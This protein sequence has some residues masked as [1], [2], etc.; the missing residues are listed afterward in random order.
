[1]K[2]TPERK[3]RKTPNES[4]YVKV[5]V[6][7]HSS[8]QFHRN[9]ILEILSVQ[10]L[11]QHITHSSRNDCFKLN[12]IMHCVLP[13]NITKTETSRTVRR[14]LYISCS[15]EN[16]QTHKM[17]MIFLAH[18]HLDACDTIMS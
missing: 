16:T 15:R 17:Q 18:K 11:F 6:F 7:L 2:S 5:S 8:S 14:R 4:I 12:V 3:K 1:M 13:Y 10:L 9:S